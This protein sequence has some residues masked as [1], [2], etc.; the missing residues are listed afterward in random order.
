MPHVGK[1]F[2]ELSDN[3][4]TLANE[5]DPRISQNI[6][7]ALELDSSEL[8]G[9]F[10]RDIQSVQ[11]DV[12]RMIED[13][14]ASHQ[15]ISENQQILER[16]IKL[17]LYVDAI[18]LTIPVYDLLNDANAK[19]DFYEQQ[20]EIMGDKDLSLAEMQRRIEELIEKSIAGR[21]ASGARTRALVLAAL[22]GAVLTAG[23]ISVATT[24]VPLAGSK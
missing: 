22:G 23:A 13:L 11:A 14:L 9:S 10:K 19:I 24:T 4:T 16:A 8:T 20:L 7:S 2:G 15:S 18:V 5:V 21:E 12:T 6:R 3:V 1:L 17:Q